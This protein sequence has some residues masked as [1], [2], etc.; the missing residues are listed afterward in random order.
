MTVSY[1]HNQINSIT[2]I[3]NDVL[4]M[5]LSIKQTFNLPTL[6]LFSNQCFEQEEFLKLSHFFV[7]LLTFLASY[8]SIFSFSIKLFK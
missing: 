1:I 6:M 7:T 8:F 4:Y 3:L 5:Y 2:L